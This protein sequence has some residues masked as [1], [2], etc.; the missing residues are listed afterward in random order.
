MA[1]VIFERKQKRKVTLNAVRMDRVISIDENCR[2]RF[3][4]GWFTHLRQVTGAPPFPPWGTI[5][6][7]AE[8]LQQVEPKS[9]LR[10]KF[11]L[12]FFVSFIQHIANVVSERAGDAARAI[13]QTQLTQQNAVEILA[14]RDAPPARVRAFLDAWLAST[15]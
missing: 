5:N 3:A 6:A 2:V 8:E 10:G 4:S 1:W 7:I 13:I 9:Y 14:A 12:W 15:T 11:E